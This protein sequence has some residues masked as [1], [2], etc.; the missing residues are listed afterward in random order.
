MPHWGPHHAPD[1]SQNKY[2]NPTCEPIFVTTMY[3]PRRYR[4]NANGQPEQVSYGGEYIITW[5]L[6]RIAEDAVSTFPAFHH[7]ASEGEVGV[8]RSAKRALACPTK[9]GTKRVC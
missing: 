3:W 8:S 4:N 9:P 2:V 1:P 7:R 6:G 5:Y